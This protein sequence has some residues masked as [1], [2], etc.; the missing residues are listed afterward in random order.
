MFSLVGKFG[1][2]K[3]KAQS[4]IFTHLLPLLFFFISLHL[5]CSFVL[6]NILSAFL[7]LQVCW[8]WILSASVHWRDVCTIYRILDWQFLL[9]TFKSCHY[10]VFWLPL[11]LITS[12]IL[13]L[14]E[15]CLAVFW[16]LSGFSLILWSSPFD[17]DVLRYLFHSV[18]PVC[19][20]LN[21]LYL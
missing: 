18:Y 1:E 13:F 7:V 3:V 12:F 11:F 5:Y 14:P 21:F 20:S 4:Y 10:F 6:K 16:L 17:H 19:S 8:Q 2:E 15:C 9:W